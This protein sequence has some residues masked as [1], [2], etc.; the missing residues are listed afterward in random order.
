M[1]EDE[2]L[3]GMGLLRRGNRLSVMPVE[4]RHLARIRQLAAGP[5]P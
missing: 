3:Q 1:K 5:Q 4:P 2:Q